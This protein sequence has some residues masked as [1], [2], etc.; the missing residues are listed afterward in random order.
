M[1]FHF[2]SSHRLD[3]DF[4]L[5]RLPEDVRSRVHIEPAPDLSNVLAPSESMALVN[6]F[7]MPMSDASHDTRTAVWTRILDFAVQKGPRDLMPYFSSW[8]DPTFYDARTAR[9]L[10]LVSRSFQVTL[11]S[12]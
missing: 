10:L 6:P 8:F 3:L 9:A 1:S 2:S 11:P 12:R 4:L 7:Y 5:P